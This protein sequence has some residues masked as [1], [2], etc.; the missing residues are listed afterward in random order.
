MFEVFL[1]DYRDAPEGQGF[2]RVADLLET[3]DQQEAVDLCVT[4]QPYL[5]EGVEAHFV[6]ADDD[7]L[8]SC[9]GE[10][11]SLGEEES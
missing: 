3:G 6:S 11:D 1:A 9:E 4:L 2:T 5:L 7:P 10:G 8:D